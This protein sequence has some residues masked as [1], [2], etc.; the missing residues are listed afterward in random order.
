M[1]P[2]LVQA[3]AAGPAGLTQLVESVQAG[4]TATATAPAVATLTQTAPAAKT[5]TV[6]KTSPAPLATG[7]A[8]RV[9]LTGV[10]A[11]AAALVAAAMF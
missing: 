2:A 8:G 7:A 5:T 3:C 11:G 9:E 1:V 4:A 10:V 6:A